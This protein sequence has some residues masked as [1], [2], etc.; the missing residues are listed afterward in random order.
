MGI[1]AISGKIGSGKDTIA[2][3]INYLIYESKL[4]GFEAS[5]ERFYLKSFLESSILYSYEIKKFAYKLKQMASLLTGI[6]VEDLEKQEVKDS[7]LGREWNKKYDIKEDEDLQA[8]NFGISH[9]LGV[10]EK[11]MTVRE[12]LQKLGTEALRDVIHPNVHV[13]ALFV[14]YI[15]DTGFSYPI[16]II[17]SNILTGE[18]QAQVLADPKQYNN[19]LP[20]WII[21]DLRFE[22]EAKAV[23]DRDGLLIR[24]KRTQWF[25]KDDLE[26]SEYIT[27]HEHPSETALDSY[28]DWD[29]VIDNDGTIE[30]LVEKVRWILKR[31]NIV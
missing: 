3:I 23:Q 15:Q 17:G 19:G 22:N 1:I 5:D 11:V 7:H 8:L 16:K 21:S 4:T 26:N 20:N 12:M 27:K 24:V 6:P 9:G 18:V 31:E 28:K 10:P 29:Y 2:K 13:N 30:E 14:D 25:K